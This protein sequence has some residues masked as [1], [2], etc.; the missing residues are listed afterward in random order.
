VGSAFDELVRLK[1]EAGF[2][3]EDGGARAVFAPDLGARVFCELEGVSLHRLD[4]G[5]VRQSDKVFNNFGGN[6]FWPAPEGG[7]FGFNYDGDTW[8]VQAAINDE[9]FALAERRR[10][11]AR[12]A[13]ETTLINRKGARL[14]VI[15]ERAFQA[16]EPAE[17]L[18]RLGPSAAFAYTVE[19]E[20]RVRGNVK[21]EDALLACWTLEQFDASDETTSFAAVERPEEAINFD[22]YDHPEDRIL[23]GKGGFLY[24][25]DGKRRGQIGVKRAACARFIGFADRG[26]KLLVLREIL[27]RTGELYFNIADNDQPKGPFSAADEYSIFNG[28]EE[29]GFFELETIGG[30]EVNAGFLKGSRL[31][32]KTSF[33]L[34]ADSAA[35]DGFVAELL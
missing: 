1:G 15:M 20:I 8:R 30:A 10:S 9:P 17:E 31:A 26:R 33:A 16:A 7:E 34:F 25:T 22:F 6:N 27:G 28:P 14:P 23:Y 18:A 29:F 12:A 32:S 4:I 3:F 21:A 11:S 35:I 2:V 24:K 19:D 5:N 13:K